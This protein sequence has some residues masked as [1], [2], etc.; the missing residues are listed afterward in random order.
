MAPFEVLL[1]GATGYIGGTVLSTISTSKDEPLNE[2]NLTLLVR[3]E[4]KARIFEE[5]GFKTVLFESLR[6]TKEVE[7]IASDYDL[8]INI[9]PGASVHSATAFIK[10]LGNRRKSTGRDVY[11]IHTSGT[12]NLADQPITNAYH[13]SRTFTDT[14]PT[15]YPYLLSR[16]A[17][18]PYA[19][20]TTD[21]AVIET[22]LASSVKTYIIMPPTIYGTGTGFFNRLTIQAPFIMRAAL[23]TGEVYQLGADDGDVEHVHVE[24]L[25]DLY[26]LMA[27]KIV[28]DGMQGFPSGERGIY[29]AGTGR[30]TW[31]EFSKGIAKAM[32]EVGGTKTDKIR[33][34]GLEEAAETWTGGNKLLCELNFGSNFRTRPDTS[35]SLGW[36][37]KRTK[38]DFDEH[39]LETAKLVM[40]S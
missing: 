7:R 13:E 20:R 23:R 3:G 9:T 5:K 24:D 39:Y 27:N 21:I 38:K 34:V 4:D 16:N 29:F 12:S 36:E 22:G 31:G 8:I 10:G 11:Y 32:Y 28:T 17:L 15:L 30:Y 14:S 35:R 2:C 26:V 25:A 37:P 18:A 19:Q 33:K 6:D 1:A 40:E